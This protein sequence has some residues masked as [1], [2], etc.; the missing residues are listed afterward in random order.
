MKLHWIKDYNLCIHRFKYKYI[1]G[2]S[3][4]IDFWVMAVNIPYEYTDSL[5]IESFFQNLM[6]NKPTT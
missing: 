4:L 6:M 3:V 5:D 2:K 1:M